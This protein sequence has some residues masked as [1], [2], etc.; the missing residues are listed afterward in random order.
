[1]INT[2]PG[3]PVTHGVGMT[4]LELGSTSPRLG[5]QC[6]FDDSVLLWGV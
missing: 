1:M 6:P 4:G 2:E 5:V 3:L